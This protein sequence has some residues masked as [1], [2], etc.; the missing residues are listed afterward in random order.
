[1]AARPNQTKKSPARRF[2]AASKPIRDGLRAIYGLFPAAFRDATEQ[3]EAGDR[4]VPARSGQSSRLGSAL[5]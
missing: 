2:H 1:V 3:L 5:S 4:S